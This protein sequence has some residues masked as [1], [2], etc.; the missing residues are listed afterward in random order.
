MQR[1]ARACRR[2]VLRARRHRGLR[3]Q[4]R[5]GGQGT[6]LRRLH[7]PQSR[8]RQGRPES[9][10]PE[11]RGHLFRQRRRRDP[12]HRTDLHQR[13][14]APHHLRGDQP[15]QRHHAGG[16]AQD[17]PLSLLVNRARMVGIVVFDDAKRFPQAVNEMAGYLKDGRMKSKEDVV[18]GASPPSR[19]C[20]TSCSRAR[21]SA[22]WY[23]RSLT[24]PT[25]PRRRGRRAANRAAL[26]SD[27]IR[28]GCRAS[29]R[30]SPSLRATVWPCRPFRPWRPSCRGTFGRWCS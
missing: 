23:S 3:G 20:S 16:W 17:P 19:R 2:R 1:L 14:G 8:Q 12:R 25:S 7:R 6:R 9:P 22:S 24:R 30:P 4:M 28:S 13:E 27:Q 5:L 15:I 11:G 26:G 18:E 10:L 21:T 29:S